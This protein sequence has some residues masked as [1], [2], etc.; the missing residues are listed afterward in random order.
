MDSTSSLPETYKALV[1]V[2]PGETPK[3]E[4][5]PLLKPGDNQILVKVAFAPIHPSDIYSMT[6]Q[7]ARPGDPNIPLVGFEGSGT[8]VALGENLKIPFTIGQKVHLRGPGTYG[9]YILVETNAAYP[10][11]GDLSLEQ[12]A[13]HGSNPGTVVYMGLLAQ[14][15]GHKAA[16]HTAG[17]SALGRMLIRYFK[18]KGIKLINIV[19]R[20]DFTQELKDEGADYVLNST[21]P[22]FEA[23]LK[24]IAE[25]EQATIAFDAI[26]G[27]FTS[28]VVTALPAGSICYIYGGLGGRTLPSISIMELFK[29]KT[30]TAFSVA[31]YMQELAKTGKTREVFSEIHTKLDTTFK[32]NIQKIF[33]LDDIVEALAYYEKN[34]SKGKI[35]LQP[36]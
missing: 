27:D 18:E 8:V 16:I 15:G 36:N 4:T 34:S 12:A 5:F 14:R 3:I 25:K 24:E 28:K 26:A 1:K 6:G 2:K 13:P 10:V 19:R 21:A 32:S 20:D 29:G 31:H 9:Q 30:I 23:Q 17:S 35:L 22:D 11:Q 33:K 7:Y